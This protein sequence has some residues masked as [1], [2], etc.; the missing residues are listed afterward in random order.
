M[1]TGFVADAAAPPRTHNPCVPVAAV[2]R[3]SS[4]HGAGPHAH[5]DKPRQECNG[6]GPSAWKDLKI[7]KGQ[8]KWLV[9]SKEQVLN[10]FLGHPHHLFFIYSKPE[11]IHMPMPSV[12]QE[13]SNKVEEQPQP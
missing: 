13:E 11:V 4:A 7:A 8:H 10:S 12:P 6:Q 5:P 3:P 2:R 9:A 1:C